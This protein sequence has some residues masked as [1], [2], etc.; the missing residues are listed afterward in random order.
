[1]KLE[2]E[3]GAKKL[4]KMKKELE[5]KNDLKLE[6][7]IEQE[8]TRLKASHRDFTQAKSKSMLLIGVISIGTMIFLNKF[9]AGKIVAILPFEPVWMFKSLAHRG[10]EGEDYTQCG[11]VFLYILC[12]MALKS[13]ISKLCGFSQSRA[14]EALNQAQMTK[15]YGLDDKKK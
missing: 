13:N 10:L 6:K 3:K 9:Y 2:L 5:T 1:M 12:N 15:S 11:F 7:R 4:S 14:V 8:E